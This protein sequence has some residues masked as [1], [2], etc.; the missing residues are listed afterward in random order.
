MDRRKYET[1]TISRAQLQALRI[2]AIETKIPVA[3]QLM[4]AHFNWIKA[5]DK[6]G[7]IKES[8]THD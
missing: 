2:I 5:A 1:F 6:E 7:T 8:N 4:Q 3:V